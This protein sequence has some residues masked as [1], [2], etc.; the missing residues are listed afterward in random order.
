MTLTPPPIPKGFLDRWCGTLAI[1]SESPPG[2]FLPTGL[3]LLSAT[4]GPRLVMRWGVTHEE[5]MNLWVLNV[6]MSALGRKT[7]GLAGLRHAVRWIRHGGDD[8]VR[9]INVTRISDAGLVSA[10]DVVSEDTAKS[11]DTD[12]DG[13]PIQIVREV[14][15]S[16]VALFNEVSPV[17]MEDGPGWAMDAQ[18]ALL[19]IY[20]GQ[21]SSTT[22]A[23]KVPTQDCFVTAIGNIPPGVLR[24]QTT[25][26]MLASG[27]VGRWLV[28]P[29]PP[30]ETI[31]SFPMPNGHDPLDALRWD[32]TRLMRLARGTDR[33]IVNDLWTRDALDHRHHWYARHRERY[34]HYDP[35][36]PLATGAAELFGRLQ[37][38][39]V[40]VATLL[41]VGRTLDDI[42]SLDDLQVES[43]DVDWASHVI[44][45]SIEYVTTSLRDAGA[46]AG[47]NQGRAEGRILRLL[48]RE[49]ARDPRTAVT[50]GRLTQTAKG[51][52][53]SRGDVIRSLDDLLQAGLI[54]IAEEGRTRRVW[55]TAGSGERT[56]A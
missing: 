41:A 3:A 23:T 21:L 51:G 55:L 52:R 10:L 20:D 24:D 36:D 38:T 15:L 9:L 30:P 45:A 31:V 35:D 14:P 42:T 1:D 43:Q 27:F 47:S 44:D 56:A 7:S 34:A 19:S 46:D 48:E 18:R 53:L 17:W 33:T 29:T 25:L 8:L 5:R 40:K 13:N 32:V 6:G 22:K 12:S 49:G 54:E 2:A 39:A 26:G 50:L 4:V 16:W 28:V 11:N 37:A